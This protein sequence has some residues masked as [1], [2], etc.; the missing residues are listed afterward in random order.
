MNHQLFRTLLSVLLHLALAVG[1][2][3]SPKV[4]VVLKAKSSF[5]YAVERGALAAGTKLGAE[6]TVLAPSSETDTAGQI[7]LLERYVEQKP[8]AIIIAVNDREALVEP[9][10]RVSAAGVKV[11]LVD[12]L[13]A[14]EPKYV[15]VGPNQR[16]AGRAAGELLALLIGD[17]DP[18][19]FVKLSQSS[20]AA[21]ERERGAFEKLKELRPHFVLRGSTYIETAAGISTESCTQIL[22]PNPDLKGILASATRATLPMIKAV[23][24]KGRADTTK[25]VGFGFNLCPEAAAAIDSG[26]LDGWI[27]QL[28]ADM[29][30]R[31]VQAALALVKGEPVP[32]AIPTDILVVTKAN[33]HEP[34]VEALLEK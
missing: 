21:A 5:W 16:D 14:G 30:F 13:L 18:V 28:P 34:K 20:G 33:L 32:A 1:L 9:L 7:Q 24:E 11:V 31:G 15:F 6:V 8:D 2:A 23:Q 25:L 10:A 27:A 4:G 29:G 3:A 22:D 17:A 12:T 19:F 26:A